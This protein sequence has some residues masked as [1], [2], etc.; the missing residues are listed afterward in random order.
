MTISLLW[1][2]KVLLWSGVV[3]SNDGTAV[4]LLK[5]LN[6]LQPV[7]RALTVEL[8]VTL[9]KAPIGRAIILG[10]GQS[11]SVISGR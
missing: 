5:E 11:P 1:K 6:Q 9:T 7:M 4:V 8:K 10:L 3:L 2:E